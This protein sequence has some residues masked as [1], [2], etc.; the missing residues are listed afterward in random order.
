MCLWGGLSVISGSS[1]AEEDKQDL[2]Q[3]CRT[4]KLHLR[5]IQ[6]V[7]SNKLSACL[8]PLT[9]CDCCHLHRHLFPARFLKQSQCFLIQPADTMNLLFGS[10]THDFIPAPFAHRL[11]F[12]L[13]QL[14]LLLPEKCLQHSE[15]AAVPEETL[16]LW[17]VT[18]VSLGDRRRLMRSVCSFL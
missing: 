7:Q 12:W 6:R 11:P 17:H 2:S 4:S 3:T 8:N 13:R 14:S 15:T 10:E 16:K 1:W 18:V 5:L 9:P